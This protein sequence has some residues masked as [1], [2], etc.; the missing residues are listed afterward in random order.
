MW[1]FVQDI[2]KSIVI[3][4]VLTGCSGSG[5][6]SMHPTV[7]TLSYL[8]FVSPTD[9]FITDAGT[10]AILR[11]GITPSKEPDVGPLIDRLRN[12]RKVTVQIHDI[13]TPLTFTI[14]GLSEKND[15]LVVCRD[16]GE[17]RQILFA[18]KFK[19]EK[20]SAEQARHDS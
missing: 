7:I 5:T 12:G 14:V 11:L 8:A 13:E 4:L 1:F 9:S 3:V 17:A 15:C 6:P 16:I 18:L 20:I 2:P 10:E 19:L